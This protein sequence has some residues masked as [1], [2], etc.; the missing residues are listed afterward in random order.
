M[1]SLSWLLSAWSIAAMRAL[2]MASVSA[3]TFIS[4]VTTCSTSASTHCLAVSRS[5][6]VGARRPSLRILSSKLPSSMAA[7]VAKGFAASAMLVPLSRS[8]VRLW[9]TYFGAELIQLLIVIQNLLQHF[10]E[11]VVSIKAATEI[12]ELSAQLNQ[13]SQRLNLLHHILRLKILHGR[14]TKFDANLG[15]V[16]GELVI[17][18]EGETRFHLGEDLVEVI[19]VDLDKLAVFDCE[20]RFIGLSRKVSE[21]A[22]NKWQLFLFNGAA[23]FYV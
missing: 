19:T 12:R 7:T 17:D 6:S 18:L 20:Q 1:I 23:R 8:R 5:S 14:E 3:D 4:L 16:V 13:L 21:N 22:D 11:L 10:F 15:I 9:H 2:I